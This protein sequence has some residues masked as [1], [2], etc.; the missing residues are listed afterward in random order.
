MS[1]PTARVLSKTI[2]GMLGQVTD[3]TTLALIA[4]EGWTY[5]AFTVGAANYI[6][7]FNIQKIDLSGYQLQDQTLFPQGVLMQDMGPQP[8][9]ISS[10]AVQRCTLVTNTPIN[11]N[12]LN[13]VSGFGN[14][15]VP[16]SLGSTF[17]LNN[18][19]AGR[20]QYFL[21]LTTY[22]G[23]Q[24]VSESSWGS[25]DSTAGE[26]LWLCDA[27]LL[28]AVDGNSVA[29]PEQSFVIPSIIAEESELEYMMRLQRSL[30]PV[31]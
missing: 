31:Y 2:G 25:G 13:V 29:A 16:G 28:S 11:V 26:A 18:V 27:Y 19:F 14:W 20:M 7:A 3:S 12:D 1:E 24:Q 5:D 15:E 17:N 4:S 10:P 23:L 9:G 21:E 8:R 22:A 6:V 30:D